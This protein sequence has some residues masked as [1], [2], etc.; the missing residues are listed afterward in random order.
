MTHTIISLNPA[1]E[2][3]VLVI[4]LNLLGRRLLGQY[5]DN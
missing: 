5:V 2:L 4:F 1:I 3:S